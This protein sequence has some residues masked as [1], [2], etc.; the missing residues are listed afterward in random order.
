MDRCLLTGLNLQITWTVAHQGFCALM[1][2][3]SL[4]N[5]R[6][7]GRGLEMVLL[8]SNYWPKFNNYIYLFI[9]IC[10]FLVMLTLHKSFCIKKERKC[11]PRGFF[12]VYQWC[13]KMADLCS[14]NTYTYLYLDHGWWSETP[15]MLAP[16]STTELRSQDLLIRPTYFAVTNKFS[17]YLSRNCLVWLWGAE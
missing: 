7:R 14:K 3:R 10:L 17:A 15:A 6:G 2:K 5:G 1:V 4:V 11:W 9:S 12:T 13:C 16:L 8:Y